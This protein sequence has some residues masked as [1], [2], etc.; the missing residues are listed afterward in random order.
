MSETKKIFLKPALSIPQQINLL[1][2]RGLVVPNNEKAIHYLR[3]IGYYRLSG[4]ASFFYE[5]FQAPEP[6]F[7]K[8]IEFDDILNLYFF[9]RKLRLLIN[10]AIERIEV[11]IRACISNVMSIRYGSHWFSNKNRFRCNFKYDEFIKKIRI[12]TGLDA[13]PGSLREKKREPMFH[14]YYTHYEKPELPPSWMIAEILSLGSWSLLFEGLLKE[15]QKEI[16]KEFDLHPYILRSWLH[17]TYLRN[18]CAHHTRVWN[19]HFKIT[20]VEMKI[21]K[22]HL[23]PNHSFYAQ[24]SMLHIFLK[25]VS[26]DTHWQHKLRELLIATP[27]RYLDA[28]GF[29]S[30]WDRDRFWLLS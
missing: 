10:D 2:R 14:Y 20:P 4:Y 22:K 16:A 26:N 25:I 8:N 19:R 17:M 23:I 5:S 28:M 3:F 27:K 15:C 21:Y 24:A 7:N 12:D 9:D 29:P 18:I 11:A 13:L 1:I 30:D 6:N